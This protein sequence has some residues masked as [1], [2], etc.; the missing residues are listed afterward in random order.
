[1]TIHQLCS[2]ID[3][4]KGPSGLSAATRLFVLT[5]FR[6]LLNQYEKHSEGDVSTFAQCRENLSCCPSLYPVV[7]N[8]CSYLYSKQFKTTADGLIADNLLTTLFKQLD[9]GVAI[10]LLNTSSRQFPHMK[11]ELLIAFKIAHPIMW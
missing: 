10:K 2:K 3:A 1:M 6:F 4:T 5:Y 7:L 8:F 11:Q 9:R